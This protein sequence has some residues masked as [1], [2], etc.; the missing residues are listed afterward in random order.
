[1][2]NMNG[3]SQEKKLSGLSLNLDISRVL[4]TLLIMMGGGLAA[5]MH[6]HMRLPLNMPGHHGLE[7]MA[8][9]TII[10]LS[11]RLRYA[12]MISM[13][14]TGFVLLVPGLGGGTILHGFAYLLPG[15]ILDLAYVAGR[16]RIRILLVIAF[17]AGFAYMVIPISRLILNAITGFPYMAF[18]KHGVTYTVLSFFFFGMMG[19]LLGSGLNSIRKFFLKPT[20]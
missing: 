2:I 19:G 14:G 16:E 11:S 4:E 6:F 10:R 3:N 7:F 12:G 18:V 5:Y 17:V 15:I 1:M 9:L 8:I 13:L 20:E